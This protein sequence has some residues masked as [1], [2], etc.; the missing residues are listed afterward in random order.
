MRSVAESE[1][2]EQQQGWML[3]LQLYRD[4]LCPSC[5][6]PREVC[7]DIA[8]D[9]KFKATPMRCHATDARLMAAERAHKEKV[10]RPEARLYAVELKA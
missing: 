6:L 1:W 9:G 5:G 7:M 4:G 10:P 2:D 3:A 8:N